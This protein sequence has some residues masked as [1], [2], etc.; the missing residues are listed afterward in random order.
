MTSTGKHWTEQAIRR[1]AD[2]LHA[3]GS[4]AGHVE[5][6][7]RLQQLYAFMHEARDLRDR[8]NAFRKE[9]PDGRK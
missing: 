9:Q 4:A 2:T 6:P 5:D 3:L 7:Q 1:L 8:L